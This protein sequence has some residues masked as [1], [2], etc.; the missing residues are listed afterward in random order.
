MYAER[1]TDH[2]GAQK[3]KYGLE[4]YTDNPDY[5]PISKEIIA[6]VLLKQLCTRHTSAN[7]IIFRKLK[8]VQ[9]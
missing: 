6:P 5:A 9:V 2:F 7:Q 3:I 1:A 8:F 4:T